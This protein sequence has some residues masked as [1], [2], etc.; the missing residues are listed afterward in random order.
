[1]CPNCPK[2]AHEILIKGGKMTHY[3]NVSVIFSDI[4]SCCP[5][6]GFKSKLIPGLTYHDKR[7]QQDSRVRTGR[8]K[9]KVGKSEA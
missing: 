2:S 7:P 3:Y 9:G 6:R 1:M 5:D 8:V 4:S